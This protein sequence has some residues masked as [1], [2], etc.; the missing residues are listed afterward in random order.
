[1]EDIIAPSETRARLVDWVELARRAVQPG[2]KRR[3]LRP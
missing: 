3:G 1:V 2:P